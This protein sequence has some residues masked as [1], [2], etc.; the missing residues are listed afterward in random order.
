MAARKATSPRKT[1]LTPRADLAVV[2]RDPRELV[3]Y[4]RNARTH[5][6][7]QILEIQS[8]ILEFGFTNPVLLR[9]E[10]NI[11]AGH[12]RTLAAVG[13]GLARVPTITLPDLSEAQW[14]AYVIADNKLALNASWDESL[15]KLEFGALKDLGF[16]LTLTG[17]T[18]DE[19]GAL[20]PLPGTPPDD[21]K[22]FGDDIDTEHECPRCKF[23]WSG[24]SEPESS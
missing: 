15:L 14:R 22:S 8:S 10:R 18:L 13:L 16:E 7:A 5:S 17:F 2:Y 11:G 20:T 24:K 21:F 3:A 19:I 1:A 9:D 4:E 6:P 12:A 23:K